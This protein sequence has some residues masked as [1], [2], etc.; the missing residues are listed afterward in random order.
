MNRRQAA[1]V[2]RWAAADA[3]AA[4]A[5]HVPG[6]LEL[7]ELLP[8]EGACALCGE[9]RRKWADL[10]DDCNDAFQDLAEMLEDRQAEAEL[11]GQMRRRA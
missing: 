11:R 3:A 10:C 4:G 6:Q 7:A 9:L 1:Q 8:T 5:V 2:E